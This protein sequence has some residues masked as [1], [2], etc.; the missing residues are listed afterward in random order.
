MKYYFSYLFPILLTFGAHL[1]ALDAHLARGQ[2]AYDAGLYLEAV[3]DFE[4]AL[5]ECEEA[6]RQQVC[7]RL[8]HAY[9]QCERYADVLTVLQDTETDE[10]LRLIAA[11]AHKHLNNLPLAYDLLQK[12][13]QPLARWHL[14]HIA[15]LLGDEAV[16]ESTW[17]E[18]VANHPQNAIR[19]LAELYL[20]KLDLTAGRYSRAREQLRSMEPRL[21]APLAYECAFYLGLAEEEHQDWL[22]ASQAYQRALPKRNLT[23]AKWAPDTLKRL[24]TCHLEL[25]EKAQGQQRIYHLAQAE[26]PLRQLEAQFPQEKWQLALAA[27]LVRKGRLQNDAQSLHEANIL[28]ADSSSCSTI[29]ERNQL[30]L[31]RAEAAPSYET[32][33]F[34]YTELL[35]RQEQGSPEYAQCLLLGAQNDLQEGQYSLAIHKLLQAQEQTPE[36]LLEIGRICALM[37]TSEAQERGLAA[38]RQGYDYSADP[39]LPYL[40]EGILLAQSTKG[41][42]SL[43]WQKAIDSFPEGRYADECLKQLGS[44]QYRQEKFT[45]ATQTFLELVA[46]YPTS[47][48]CGEALYWVARAQEKSGAPRKTTQKSFCE[49]YEKYP[50]CKFAPE[51]YLALYT[52]AEYLSEPLAHAHLS[53]MKTRFPASALT[54]NAQHLLGLALRRLPPATDKRKSPTSRWHQAIEAFQEAELAFDSLY[55]A[56]LIQEQDIPRC[57]TLRCRAKLERALANLAIASDAIGAKKRIYLGYT[58]D[59]FHELLLDMDQAP[60]KNEALEPIREEAA[61]G[62]AVTLVRSGD[63]KIAEPMLDNTIARYQASGVS[64]GYFFSRTLYQKGNLYLRN[65]QHEQGLSLFQR[66]EEAAKGNLLSPEEKLDL[67]LAQSQCLQQLGRLDEAMLVLSKVI[68]EDAISALRVKAMFLRAEIYQ[69]QGRQELA[70]KQLE[71]TSKK[72][73]EW[74]LKAKEKLEQAYGYE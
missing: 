29:T 8:A 74:A 24:A 58:S 56:G 15:Y 48:H 23:R 45:E 3:N 40:L 28:L 47:P 57:T 63:L 66:S 21:S 44:W 25:A 2:R 67:W 6:N 64:R 4:Q 37:H 32:R 31:L 17:R 30:L 20:A 9:H 52:Y 38:I 19:P 69:Q 12:C 35:Q 49:V 55:A 53:E 61:Y 10:E 27:F 72:G 33:R 60:W 54:I 11:L 43:P 14:G 41:D 50:Q 71:A 1:C 73:G 22:L 59:L 42:P 5:E 26:L 39:D 34:F 62:L 46:R 51:A 68:N 18:L 36:V 16:A 70:Q 7:T 65:G 13:A